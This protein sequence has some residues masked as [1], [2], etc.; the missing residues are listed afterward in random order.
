MKKFVIAFC[1]VPVFALAQPK[2]WSEA[3]VA[4][5]Y[6][7]KTTKTELIRAIECLKANPAA[8]EAA[9]GEFKRV[10]SEL[11]AND[12]DME[13]LLG[14]L[15]RQK[16]TKLYVRYYSNYNRTKLMIVERAILGGRTPI[17]LHDLAALDLR[18]TTA[19]AHWGSDKT[20]PLSQVR[21]FRYTS[22]MQNI[23]ELVT[24]L[25]DGSEIVDSS[26]QGGYPIKE[27]EPQGDWHG[28]AEFIGTT[29]PD[30]IAND[31]LKLG[32]SSLSTFV[33]TF[34]PAEEGKRLVAQHERQLAEQRSAKA[35]ADREAVESRRLAA[36]AEEAR[37]AA[38][39]ATMSRAERGLEDSCKRVGDFFA[40]GDP[41][42]VDIECQFSGRTSL[43]GL[44]PAGWLIVNKQRDTNGTVREYLIRKAR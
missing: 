31:N 41:E 40:T 22:K 42:E 15:G 37:K 27:Y 1:L 16:S 20:V 29:Y 24:T 4:D 34:V 9:V 2:D 19:S 44:K 13:A 18:F 23:G 7:G 25:A 39:I 10:K 38:V 17:V 6:N 14:D 12:A 43:A 3:A 8:G 28:I 33:I 11:L 32:P 26:Y 36:Q 35:K 5:C 21:S 30:G